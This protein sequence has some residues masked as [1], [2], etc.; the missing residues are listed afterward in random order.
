MEAQVQSQV[1]PCTF[2]G[3]QNDTEGG[4]FQVP[5]FYIASHHPTNNSIFVTTPEVYDRLDQSDCYHN[6]DPELGLHLLPDT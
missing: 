1:I 6:F 2:Y 5:W 4:S 3:G